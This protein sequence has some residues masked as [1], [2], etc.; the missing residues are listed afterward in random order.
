M[1][2]PETDGDDT[3]VTTFAYKNYGVRSNRYR[4]IVY[5]DGT[6]ELYDHTKDKWEC[7]NLAGNPEYAEVK[8]MMRKG[9]PAHHEPSGPTYNPP[10]RKRKAR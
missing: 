10:G 2:D 1:K 7:K 6:E 5:R 4:F 3:T 9:I 8:K